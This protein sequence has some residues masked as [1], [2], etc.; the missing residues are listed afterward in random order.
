MENY[1]TSIQPFYRLA[2]FFGLFPMSYK[3][4]VRRGIL[5]FTI[6]GFIRTLLAFLVL[7]TML[8]FIFI[9]HIMLLMEQRPFLINTVWSWFLIIIYPVIIFQLILQAIKMKKIRSFFIF[10]NEIDSKLQQLQ[11]LLDH[12]KHRRFISYNLAFL[13]GIMLIRFILQGYALLKSGSRY[14]TRAS[15]AVQEICFLWF[16]FYYCLLSLQF[17][18][19]TYLVRERFRALKDL[20]R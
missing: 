12:K 11:V 10:M 19:I 5:K 13:V 18:F 16:L 14:R 17:V 4:P 7:F 6:C 2:K 1:F 20:L 15:V 8:F 9:N 3:G